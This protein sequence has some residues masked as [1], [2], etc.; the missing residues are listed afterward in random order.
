[1][2]CRKCRPCGIYLSMAATLLM[3]SGAIAHADNRSEPIQIQA[4]RMTLNEEQGLSRYFGKV[5]LRQGRLE[6]YADSIELYNQT[7]KL[8]HFVATGTP[9]RFHDRVEG[10]GRTIEGQ[11]DIIEYKA[12]TSTLTLVGNAQLRQGTDSLNGERISYNTTT[13]MVKA[14]GGGTGQDNDRVRVIIQ[15]PADNNSP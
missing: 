14:S 4:D 9:A 12:G 7:G 5:E 10:K 8:T 1:M 6:L 2:P 15:A 13:Q 3:G 11:A